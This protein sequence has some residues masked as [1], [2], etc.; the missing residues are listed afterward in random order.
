[1][2]YKGLQKRSKK[3]T[4]NEKTGKFN[5]KRRFGQSLANKAPSMFLVILDNKLKWH[6]EKLLKVDTYS[7]KASQ[8]NHFTDECVKKDLS[9]RWNEFEDK[10]VQR[11]L[12]SAY[13]IMNSD[14]KLKNTDRSLCFENWDWFHKMHDSE[15]KRIRS[16]DRKLISSMGI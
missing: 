13:L 1:M 9:E 10:Q 3:T 4:V 15:I 14:E 16:C 11:D 6:G 8:Y 2:N 5:K 12:Y 7:F